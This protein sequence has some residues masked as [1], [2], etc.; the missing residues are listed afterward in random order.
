MAPKKTAAA[1]GRKAGAKAGNVRF[2]VQV[3][4]DQVDAVVAEA[5]RRR[6]PGSVRAD[7]SAVVRDALDA[8]APLKSKR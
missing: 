1:A 2:V 7:T 5:T 3:R 8:Y 6:A 4:P